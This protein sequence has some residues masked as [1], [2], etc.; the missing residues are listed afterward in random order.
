MIG[1]KVGKLLARLDDSDLSREV[2]TQEAVLDAAEATVQRTIADEAR[3][4]AVLAQARLDYDRYS[5][6]LKNPKAF[7]RSRWTRRPRKSRCSRG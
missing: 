7:L 5:G 2:T 6:L 4:K 3:A 1:S